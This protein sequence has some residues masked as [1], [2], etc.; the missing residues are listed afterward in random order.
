MTVKRTFPDELAWLAVALVAGAILVVS[1]IPIPES[2]PEE[3][4]GV[5]IAVLFHFVGYAVL[6]VALAAALWPRRLRY[7][8]GGAFLGASACGAFA[9]LLQSGLPHRTFSY[10]DMAINAAG[11]ATGAALVLVVVL[12]RPSE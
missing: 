1:V 3:G 11:A 8:I 10:L 4:G 7:A 6:A 5:P 2:T 12:L 9:E